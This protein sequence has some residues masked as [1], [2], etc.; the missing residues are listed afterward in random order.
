MK[1]R[2]LT[3]AIAITC[4]FNAICMANDMT[5][6]LEH[7]LTEFIKD[8]D[9]TIGISVIIDS[10]DT[11]AINGDRLFPM[12]SVY[13]LPIALAF[14][15]HSRASDHIYNSII[16]LGKSDLKPDT[17]SPMRDKYAG[18]D[19]INVPLDEIFAYSL[20]QSDNN[21]SDIILKLMG[22]TQNV[23]TALK[24]L[25]VTDVNI[26]STEDEMHQRPE[27][28]YENSATPNGMARLI[29]IF[30]KEYN[31]I[32]SQKIKHLMETCSTGTNRLPQPTVGTGAVIGHKTGTGFDLPDGRLMAVNDAG[33]V[34]LP[35]G[36]HYTI[37]VFIENSGYDMTGTES[38]IAEISRLVYNVACNY[39]KNH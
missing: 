19:S 26:I 2:I 9:A 37:V 15:E 34:H 31:D 13:K 4:L 12:L 23:R 17:Y 33:Y 6:K 25:G 29:D 35:N 1:I 16:P 5:Q 38:M 24:T 27:L 18:Q 21:A 11:V 14:G 8:K 32:F 28:C 22:G 39:Y 3:V 7:Q 30:D 36:H 20:Q 10:K